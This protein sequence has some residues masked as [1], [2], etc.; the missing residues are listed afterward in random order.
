[1]TVVAPDKPG[2]LA[3]VTGVLCLHGLDLRSADVAGEDGV[4]LE[5]FVVQPATEGGPTGRG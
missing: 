5:V 1:M 3:S 4:A 2:L